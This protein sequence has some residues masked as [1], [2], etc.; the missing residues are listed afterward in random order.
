M[1][2]EVAINSAPAAIDRTLTYVVPPELQAGIQEGS[3]VLVTVGKKP[4]TALVVG[5]ADQTR[6]E[7]LKAIKAVL[8]RDFL[9][10]AMIALGRYLEERY[11]CSRTLAMNVLL[12]P[13]T[14]RRLERQ[15]CWLP[16]TGAETE[17]ALSLAACLLAPAGAVATYLAG[18]GI[19]G[20]GQLQHLG[21]RRELAV[22]LA[23]LKSH[24]LIQEEWAWEEA[25][26]ER[27][28]AWVTA[29]EE[30]A[31]AVATLDKKAPRQAAIL[32][33]LLAGGPQPAAS[34]AG[35]GGYTALHRL[36]EQGLVALAP[37]VLASSGELSPPIE[38][39]T[40]QEEAA[41]AI[42]AALGR[43]EV[44]LLHG[45]TGSGKTEVY[46][47]CAGEALARGYQVLFLVPEHSLIPQ[48]LARL[49]QRFGAG[50][51]VVRGDLAAGARFSV[52][53]Q[54][55]HGEIAVVT[56]S[57]AALFTPLPRLGLIVVDEE[58][59]GS[60]K[61]DSTPRYDAR[62]VAI[63]R[64]RME[65][66][67]V[68]LGSAT[69]STESFYLARQGKI[70]LLQ[71][72]D[73]AGNANLP[74]VEIVDLRAEFRA[75]HQGILSRR[76]Q[77]GITAILASGQQAILFLN[78]R[79]YAPHVL[80]RSCGY[81]PLCRHCAVALTY[82][83]DGNLRCHYCGY[84]ARAATACPECGGGMVQLGSG[85][86]RVEE[87]VVT[88]WPG[89]RILRADRDT[90]AR[91]GQWERIYRAFTTGQADILIG[92]QTI[93]KGMD[94]PGVS[95]VGVVNAD[96]SLYQPDFRARERTFQ[97]LT[98]VA[99]RAGRRHGGGEVIVQ[100]YNPADPAIVLAASQ[101][102]Q[103]FY[104]QEIARRRDLG[105]PPFVKLVRLGFTGMEE[106]RV[107]ETAHKVAGLLQ[108][109][110]HRVQVLGPAPGYPPR[111]K[112]SYR[113]QLILKINAWSRYKNYLAGVL[114]PYRNRHDVRMIIDVGPVNPW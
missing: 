43:S 97:L 75:G 24:G 107:I 52:W 2:V 74:Q 42:N 60:Y 91:K 95:L 103:R 34:L 108:V 112:D 44:F 82:H 53:E 11:L 71:L 93:T 65:G 3:L 23:A 70:K 55:R 33:E 28:P 32:K 10:P 1:L 77:Q 102:Y 96:L 40:A 4:A 105:Y 113:W 9:P 81:V 27:R 68:V 51:A 90:T 109:K 18:H 110:E 19:A 66:A 73:R 14:T 59:A 98:Q 17:G 83:H 16:A 64:G 101:D 5:R 86:Q 12:P 72:P 106:A 79:G 41:A 111:L 100:T 56:G 92:T 50:V 47:R 15:W 85:T 13:A 58:H 54:A 36:E 94:F 76:L 67:V 8:D 78:R 57:R 20:E 37:P 45:V 46:L 21:R 80:C 22:A 114:A 29:R 49:Q 88:L 39:N 26:R 62:E 31:A 69:P 84:V 104:E 48:I 87:E 61:Q 63:K 7:G 99:G 25:P 38:L 6:R 30:A 35:R 89:A